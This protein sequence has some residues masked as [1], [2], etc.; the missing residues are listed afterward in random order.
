MR[1]PNREGSTCLGTG[2]NR[3]SPF[4]DLVMVS[5]RSRRVFGRQQAGLPS[6]VGRPC[7]YRKL[8]AKCGKS[9]KLK[10]A[11][12]QKAPFHES[13]LKG[14]RLLNDLQ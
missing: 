14:R 3:T 10:G 11:P 1:F 9:P 4:V 12:A 5:P 2:H 6:Q 8:L 13:I 7:A